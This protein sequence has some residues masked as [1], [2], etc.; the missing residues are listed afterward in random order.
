M[1]ENLYLVTGG[2]GFLGINLCRFLLARGFRVRSLDI[3]PFEYPEQGAVEAVLGDVRDQAAVDAALEGV[4]IVVH[5]AAKLPLC[6][7]QEIFS[8]NVEGT[9][10]ML[11]SIHRPGAHVEVARKRK[12]E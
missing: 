6:D 10:L 7:A 1:A 9:R 8:T 4:D 5:C 2:S 3:A 11:E 12:S